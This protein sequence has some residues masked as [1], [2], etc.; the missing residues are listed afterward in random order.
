MSVV[1]LG[2]LAECNQFRLDNILYELNEFNDLSFSK[3]CRYCGGINFLI[4]SKN[5]LEMMR[6]LAISDFIVQNG[7]QLVFH[8][9][10]KQTTCSS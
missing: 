10:V 6:N 2:L 5:S 1:A 7:C 8:L 4:R 3:R 9:T